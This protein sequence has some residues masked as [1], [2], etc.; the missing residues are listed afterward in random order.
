M[1]CGGKTH[2]DVDLLEGIHESGVDLGKETHGEDNGETEYQSEH[3][4]SCDGEIR[5]V[6]PG[7]AVQFEPRN[8]GIQ[9]SLVME[10]RVYTS[11][12]K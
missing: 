10:I 8:I 12:V 2:L 7:P 6:T 11:T 3:E 9:A 5:R 4:V 1:D